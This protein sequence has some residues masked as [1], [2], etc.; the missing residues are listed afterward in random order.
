MGEG[1]EN[2]SDGAADATYLRFRFSVG[3][4]EEGREKGMEEGRE[5]KSGRRAGSGRRGKGERLAEETRCRGRGERGEEM[6]RGRGRGSGK[7]GGAG[8][9]RGEGKGGRAR[10]PL[11]WKARDPTLPPWAEKWRWVWEEGEWRMTKEE[12]AYTTSPPL[13]PTPAEGRAPPT[14]SRRRQSSGGSSSRGCR[15][16]GEVR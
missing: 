8:G 6:G 7:G 13:T 9:G 12:E 14:H 11:G 2:A 10:L 15:G 16:G 4:W 1:G 3:G 5:R